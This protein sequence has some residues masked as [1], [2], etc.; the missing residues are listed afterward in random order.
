MTQ[1]HCCVW[2]GAAR[3]CSKRAELDGLI[4]NS[5][6]SALAPDIGDY[7]HALPSPPLSLPQVRSLK[8]LRRC[9]RART[10]VQLDQVGNAHAYCSCNQPG[11]AASQHVVRSLSRPPSFSLLLCS[12]SSFPIIQLCISAKAT[13]A[14]GRGTAHSE[15]AS[16][17]KGGSSGDVGGGGS[18]KERERKR[19]HSGDSGSGSDT[20]G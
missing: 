12:P 4:Q 16:L 8:S 11:V 20:S 14:G 19:R 9:A 2:C 15:G 13:G 1:L 5:L 3:G 6:I 7:L 10:A 17:E 18:G